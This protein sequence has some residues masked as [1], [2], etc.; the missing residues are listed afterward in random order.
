[1]D[2]QVEI[3]SSPDLLDDAFR[4]L[5]LTPGQAASAFGG[6]PS[7]TGLLLPS[8]AVSI[9]AKKNTEHH[10]NYHPVV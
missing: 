5:K 8:W 3:L 10:R 7:T 4:N 1:M 6:T 9:V 2:T